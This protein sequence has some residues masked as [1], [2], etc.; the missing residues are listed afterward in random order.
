MPFERSRRDL[1]YPARICCRSASSLSCGGVTTTVNLVNL[2]SCCLLALVVIR[3]F[4]EGRDLC[5]PV[6]AFG[7]VV[8]GSGNTTGDYKVEKLVVG[9]KRNRTIRVFTGLLILL[10]DEY[11]R[12]G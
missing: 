11:I 2:I 4:Q 6:F 8:P 12:P 5:F 7:S 1:Q 3:S 10:P 9:H